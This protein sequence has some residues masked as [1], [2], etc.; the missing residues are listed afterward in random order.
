MIVCLCNRVSDRDIHHAVQHKGVRDFEVLQ[1]LT[2][3]ASCCGCCQ[4]CARDVFDHACT[5]ADRQA[6]APRPV[7]DMAMGAMGAAAA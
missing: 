3:V 7:Y 2:L 5:Q 1:D 6:A 4:D